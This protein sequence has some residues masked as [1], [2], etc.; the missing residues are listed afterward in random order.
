[1]CFTVFLII[2]GVYLGPVRGATVAP[3]R[4][5]IGLAR[6][7]DIKVRESSALEH[8]V[9]PGVI[10][11]TYIFFIVHQYTISEVIVVGLVDI[12]GLAGIVYSVYMKIVERDVLLFHHYIGNKDGFLGFIKQ[13]YI[14]SR[15]PPLVYLSCRLIGVFGGKID[16]MNIIGGDRSISI[17]E[18]KECAFFGFVMECLDDRP[19]HNGFG[20]FVVGPYGL[21]YLYILDGFRFPRCESH[22]CPSDEARI[23]PLDWTWTGEFS[24]GCGFSDDEIS[25]YIPILGIQRMG[26]RLSGRNNGFF[27]NIVHIPYLADGIST[28]ATR[29]SCWTAECIAYLH[30]IGSYGVIGGIGE[31]TGCPRGYVRIVY[32]SHGARLVESHGAETR[33]TRGVRFGTGCVGASI[34]TVT[35]P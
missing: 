4:S 1:M 2:T 18:C 35:V 30:E 26:M 7:T 3:D 6:R 14:F 31:G 12:A 19:I 20:D 29:R 28:T 5:R 8:I 34:D 25:L 33:G 24:I 15:L 21:A 32:F 27:H 23:A 10:E 9:I 22:L 16:E 11:R 17:L 13:V